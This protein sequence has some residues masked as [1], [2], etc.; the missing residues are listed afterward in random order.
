VTTLTALGIASLLFCIGFT[1]RAWFQAETTGLLRQTRRQAMLEAW[2]NIVIGFS[3]NACLNLLLLP[4]I[5]AHI[6]GGQ[7]FWLGTIY[8]AVSLVRSYVIR[9]YCEQHIHQLAARAAE[10]IA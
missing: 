5:G 8:T 3:I 10:R 6:S 4:L 2:T 9:R 7:N 1:G